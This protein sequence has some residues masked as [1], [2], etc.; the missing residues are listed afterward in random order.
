[1]VH[2]PNGLVMLMDFLWGQTNKTQ[3]FHR[4][5]KPIF[6]SCDSSFKIASDFEC[7]NQP[8]I[9]KAGYNGLLQCVWTETGVFL[10]DRNDTLHIL[11][12]EEGIAAT[13]KSK[14]HRIYPCEDILVCHM[15]GSSALMNI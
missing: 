14:V 5:R 3:E 12:K 2:K 1:M 4:C 13:T 11:S 9:T 10:L 6:M 15:D 7:Q 8:D